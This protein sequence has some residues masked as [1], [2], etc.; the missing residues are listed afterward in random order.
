M[1]SLVRTG[2]GQFHLENYR[3]VVVERHWSSQD[4]QDVGEGFQGVETELKLATWRQARR[5]VVLRRQVKGEVL[6]EA[7]GQ[8]AKRQ[9]SLQF[10]EP[11]QAVKLWEYTVLVT[12]ADYRLDAIGQL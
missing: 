10:A 2:L 5:V 6:V 3:T 7:K 8:R 11:L 12:N 9:A 4:W 1:Q